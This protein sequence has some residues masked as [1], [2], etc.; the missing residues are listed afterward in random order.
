VPTYGSPDGCASLD[1]SG[2]KFAFGVADADAAEATESPFAF[3][4][5]TVNVYAVS[6]VRPV[7]L[8]GEDVPVAVVPS[9]AVTT[10]PVI[11]D[12][13]LLVGGVNEIDALASSADA[14]TLVGALGTV[15]GLTAD[16]AVDCADVPI[17]FVAVT[18]NVYG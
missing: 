16:E 18:L 14:T 13:P 9:L 8:I 6:F 12:P 1:K 17:P 5:L 3:D 7:I 15:D 4:A 2:A 10:Y 11:D